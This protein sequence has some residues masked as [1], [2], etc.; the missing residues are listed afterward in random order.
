MKFLK[1]LLFPFILP[2]YIL[3]FILLAITKA[4]PLF[5]K[6]LKKLPELYA[7]VSTLF[8]GYVVYYDY[9]HNN[10]IGLN[11]QLTT[12]ELIIKCLAVFT[13]S[14]III[15]VGIAICKLIWWVLSKILLFVSIIEKSFVSV[16]FYFHRFYKTTI[17]DIINRKYAFSDNN[18]YQLKNIDSSKYK[19]VEID[20]KKYMYPLLLEY[21]KAEIKQ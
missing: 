18:V 11:S 10:L 12:N 9:T 13:I 14:I 8:I 6:W 17:Y 20:N 4:L 2:I 19:V 7:F 1:L 15:S 5:F 16:F 3:F 21:T